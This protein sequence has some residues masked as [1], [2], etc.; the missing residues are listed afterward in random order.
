MDNGL[1]TILVH[2]LLRKY[3]PGKGPGLSLSLFLS[4][5]TQLAA[6][7]GKSVRDAKTSSAYATSAFFLAHLIDNTTNELSLWS[8]SISSPQYRYKHGP[9]PIWAAGNS[10]KL[11]PPWPM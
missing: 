4:A 5:C 7:R 3:F 1:I 2:F 8:R 11:H 9:V 6:H 10:K